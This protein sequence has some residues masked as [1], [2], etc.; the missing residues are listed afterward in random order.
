MQLYGNLRGNSTLR[1][2]LHNL[3]KIAWLLPQY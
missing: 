2:H 1:C 3:Y